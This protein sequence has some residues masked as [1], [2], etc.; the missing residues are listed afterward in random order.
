MGVCG[1]RALDFCRDPINGAHPDLRRMNETLLKLDNYWG[2]INQQHYNEGKGG[3]NGYNLVP[4]AKRDEIQDKLLDFIQFGD[5]LIAQ[6]IH[7][8]CALEYV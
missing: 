6:E 1:I 5:P 8:S 2:Y 3:V 4:Y 7:K